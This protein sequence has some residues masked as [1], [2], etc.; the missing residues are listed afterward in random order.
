MGFSPPRL[1]KQHQ[2]TNVDFIG[3]ST[4]HGMLYY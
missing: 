2:Q 4:N 1:T 3:R